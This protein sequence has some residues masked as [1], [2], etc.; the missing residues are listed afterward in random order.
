MKR[1]LLLQSYADVGELVFE[2]NT[3]K[4][5]LGEGAEVVSVTTLDKDV[6]WRDPAGIIAGFDAV[7]FGGSSEFDF[8]G[9]RAAD[10]P[11]TAAS[12]EIL[13]R[14]R[15]LIEYVLANNVPCF[16]VCFGHQLIGAA[17][18]VFVINDKAQS[19]VGSYPTMLTEAGKSDRLLVG[20]PEQFIAQYGHKDSLSDLPKGATVL[21][22]SDRCRF[23]MLRY[24]TMCYTTQFHPELDLADMEDEYRVAPHRFPNDVPPAEFLK[25]SPEANTI[26]AKFLERAVLQ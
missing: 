10:D 3:Y 4:R 2:L 19:K 20:M 14:L 7:I 26:L 17:H 13:E 5:A 18:G 6:D 23:A 22:Q 1:V 15:P 11:V 21:V 12:R 25:P 24:G 8:D 16:G 9:G